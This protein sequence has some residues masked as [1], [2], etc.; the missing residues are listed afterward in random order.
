MYGWLIVF[1]LSVP[2]VTP[3]ANQD[4]LRPVNLRTDL[5]QLADLIEI[6]FADTMDHHGRAAVREMRA[7]SHMGGLTSLI[8]VNNELIQGMGMGFVWIDG[9]KL[10]GNVSVY[11]A[12]LP[13]GAARIFGST[14]MIANV[15][16]H[17]D[18]RGRGIARRL[19]EASLDSIRKRAALMRGGNPRAVAIL[20]VEEKNTPARQLY[21]T[22]G[23]RTERTWNHWKR[24]SM[25]RVM[26]PRQDS[27]IYISR[28]RRS[29]WRGEFELAQRI[30]PAE[31][32]GIGWL[33]PTFPGLFTASLWSLLSDL[34]N[35]RSV[36]HLVIRSEDERAVLAALWIENALAASS[37]QLTLMVDPD[38]TGL[39]DDALISYA[40]R[41]FGASS[42]L[43]IEHPADET[44]TNALLARYHFHVQ[45]TFVNMRW[46]T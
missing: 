20:Q 18:Y 46:E 5:S 14:W 30:R 24:S 10:V 45:R 25:S 11:P 32:G 3:A 41:R 16:T 37:I 38:Y 28:R 9:G 44:V 23:F 36:E 21:E 34:A 27:R 33:R 43:T 8:S 19:M 1:T 4:G 42:P 17:P 29:E 15:A 31:R 22:L 13:R 35:L 26:M 2:N 6:A 12:S 40:V 7:L 39:Y